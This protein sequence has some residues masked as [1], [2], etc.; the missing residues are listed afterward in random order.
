MGI[1][2]EDAAPVRSVAEWVRFLAGFGLGGCIPVDYALVGEFTPRKQRGKVLTAMDGWWPIGA[3][4][5]GFVSAGLIAAFGISGSLFA[6]FPFIVLYL[7]TGLGLTAMQTG[8]DLS[9]H[10]EIS[11]GLVLSAGPVSQVGQPLVGDA[12]VALEVGVVL[13][14]TH[15]EVA[16]PGHALTS[17]AVSR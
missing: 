11:S 3:A 8:T 4:L 10:A 6:L 14:R 9:S 16:V 17:S 5:C 15:P 7:Q 2:T 1:S 13:E 12:Q